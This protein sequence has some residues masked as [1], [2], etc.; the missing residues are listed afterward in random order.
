MQISKD[1][2]NETHVYI[3]KNSARV[4]MEA[5]RTVK[6]SNQET[7][8]IYLSAFTLFHLNHAD[9]SGL[10]VCHIL[11]LNYCHRSRS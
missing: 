1:E 10:Y 6:V 3:G 9:K 2:N 11:Q 5:Q 7:R 4:K 8:S